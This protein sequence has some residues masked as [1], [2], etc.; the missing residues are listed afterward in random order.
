MG[1]LRPPLLTP[2]PPPLA[3]A[4][5]A[6]VLLRA[7]HAPPVP[8]QGCVWLILR[9]SSTL[10][11]STRTSVIP[12]QASASFR[13]ETLTGATRG[14]TSAMCPALV[15]P[16]SGPHRGTGATTQTSEVCLPS[17]PTLQVWSREAGG[18]GAAQHCQGTQAGRVAV[19][20]AQ[21]VSWGRAMDTHIQMGGG[22][23]IL[24]GAREE[25]TDIRV[26]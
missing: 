4:P 7:T 11:L 6:P 22:V 24:R 2:L 19:S 18:W 8:S 25:A 9:A 17:G 15:G 1:P 13:F 5:P 21:Q 16:S 14:R 10:W 20:Q 26:H 12:T 3:Q 23:T